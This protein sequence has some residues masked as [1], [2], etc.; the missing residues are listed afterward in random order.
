MCM[1]LTR[2]S[3]GPLTG[4][5][6]INQPVRFT[7]SVLLAHYMDEDAKAQRGE[8]H[9]SRPHNQDLGGLVVNCVTST[10]IPEGRLLVEVLTLTPM[11]VPGPDP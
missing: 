1:A 9:L 5:P 8:L 4:S 2:P 7:A 11:G 10:K 3:T 6:F